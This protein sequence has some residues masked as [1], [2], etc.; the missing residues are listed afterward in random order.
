[1]AKNNLTPGQIIRRRRANYL[2]TQ[3]YVNLVWKI[4]VLLLA[5]WLLLSQGFLVTQVQGNE[6]FP[7]MEDGDLVLGYRLQDEWNKGDV[8]VFTMEGKTRIGRILGRP[9]DVIHMDEEGTL[10]INGTPQSGDILYPTYPPEG[11]EFPLTVPENCFYVLC[12][13]RTQCEDSRT[14]GPVPMENVQAKVITILRR[15]GI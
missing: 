14:Y 12:D 9:G 8:I 1:M 11:S 6:M 3:G 7:A 15:R 2:I 5:I 4:L 13:Y 10:R